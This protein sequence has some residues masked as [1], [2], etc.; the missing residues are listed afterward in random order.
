MNIEELWL[1]CLVDEDVVIFFQKGGKSCA[2]S[3]GG[4]VSSHVDIATDLGWQASSLLANR[5]SIVS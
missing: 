3:H 1:A 2:F 4:S 5:P